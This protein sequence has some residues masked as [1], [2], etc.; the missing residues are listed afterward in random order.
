MF[1]Q[2]HVVVNGKDYQV[3][4]EEVSGTGAEVQE[5][6]T[7]RSQ[8]QSTPVTSSSSQSVKTEGKEIH[9]PMPGTILSVKKTVGDI[10]KTGEPIMILEAMKMENDIVSPID[11]KL[12]S[13]LVKAGDT[14]N[15][16]DVIA[17]VKE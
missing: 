10:V 8:A 15:S 16:N 6:S 5:N 3:A 4:V 7:V 11:G 13:V 1:K 12:I 14:V 17:T 2:F 9:A